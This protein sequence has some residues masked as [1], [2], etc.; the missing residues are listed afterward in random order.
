MTS[1]S[2][3]SLSDI[4]PPLENDQ[5]PANAW[6]RNT[7]LGSPKWVEWPEVLFSNQLFQRYS[8]LSLLWV[9]SSHLLRCPPSI[10][11]IM[12]TQSLF[13]RPDLFSNLILP[14]PW[15]YR[16]FS[17][18]V[19]VKIFTYFGSS[20]H[21]WFSLQINWKATNNARATAGTLGCFGI[22]SA[23]L[24]SPPYLN[25]ASHKIPRHR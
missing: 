5:Q 16:Y 4:L 12:L 23:R 2:A 3:T 24:I 8:P 1:R 21:C 19:K 6:S 22:S 11:P 7:G 13:I 18:L 14:W 15:L 9:G 17:F 25:S 20:F 10:F